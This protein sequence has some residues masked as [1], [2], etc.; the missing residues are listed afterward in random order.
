MFGTLLASSVQLAVAGAVETFYQVE[1]Q[2]TYQSNP[3]FE[4]ND[5]TSVF[6]LKIKPSVQFEYADELNQYHLDLGLAIY[7]NTNE[8]FL[9]N[10]IAPEIVA[11]WSRELEFGQIGVEAKYDRIASRAESLTL[12]GAVN[13]VENVTDTASIKGIFNID[14]S[15][16][17]SLNNAA[18]YTDVQYSEELTGLLNDYNLIGASTQL[19]YKSSDRFT[20]YA[21]V[22]YSDLDPSGSAITDSD[23]YALL[24]G[25]IYTPSEDIKVDLGIGS[26]DASGRFDDRGLQLESEGFY[27]YN[28]TRV[29]YTLH[30]KMVAGGNGIYQLNTLVDLGGIYQLTERSDFRASYARSKLRQDRAVSSFDTVYDRYSLAYERTYEDWKASVFIDFVGLDLDGDQRRQNVI[31]LQV[32]F[33]PFD[34]DDLRRN[35]LNF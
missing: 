32:S 33:D 5:E 1:S 23:V 18:Q 3:G 17:F 22:D 16:K 14:F 19:N 31:G 20:T 6:A 35:P 4:D 29:Y 30:R 2:L 25:G 28:R 7:Q 11:D 15:E 27:N 8:D 10:Y 12:N 24:V 13:D 26:Y 21:K 9:L 34:F